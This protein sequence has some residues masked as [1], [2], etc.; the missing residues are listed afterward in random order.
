MAILGNTA[1]GLAEGVASPLFGLIDN[2]FTSDEERA[3]AKLK[4]LEMEQRG[5]LDSMK[6]QLSAILAEANSRDPWTSRA[7]P[8]FLYLIYAIILLC[9]FGAII[10]IWWP[11][12]VATAASNLTNLLMA[13]P[14]S[15]WW[16]FGAGYLGYTS[17]RSFDKWRGAGR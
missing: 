5:D 10:G 17:A 15:L 4:V 11:D 6:V 1:R 9:V 13:I 12:H 2:L 14:E 3:A 8:T 7:R 16:L